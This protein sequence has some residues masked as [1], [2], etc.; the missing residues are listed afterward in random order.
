[1]S[2]VHMFLKDGHVRVTWRDGYGTERDDGLVL[3]RHALASQIDFINANRIECIDIALGDPRSIVDQAYRESR[4]RQ[5]QA[6]DTPSEP[7]YDVDLRPLLACPQLVQLTLSGNLL[8]SDVLA[9]L[10]NLRT[11][12]LDNTLCKQQIDLSLLSL[13]TLY[14]QKPSRN[15]QGIGQILSLRQLAIWN[16]HPKSRNLTELQNLTNLQT[17]K[18]IQPRIDSLDGIEFMCALDTLEVYLARTLKDITALDRCSH[19]IAY[20]TDPNHAG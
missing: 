20:F 4:L 6:E 1:M 19:M 3:S 15:I 16:Y 5:L 11:L 9:S 10:P 18:L 14:L 17:L 7:S 13:D 8:G 2:G 12:N